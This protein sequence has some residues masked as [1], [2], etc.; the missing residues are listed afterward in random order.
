MMFRRR[1]TDGPKPLPP[2]LI[3]HARTPYQTAAED[4]TGLIPFYRGYSDCARSIIAMNPYL[5]GSPASKM[6]SAGSIQW[7]ADERRFR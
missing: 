7:S 1:K 5:P 4:D 3:P 2:E 6:W